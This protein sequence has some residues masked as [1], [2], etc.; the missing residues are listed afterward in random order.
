MRST[1]CWGPCTRRTGTRSQAR[2]WRWRLALGA[3][4]AAAQ[5]RRDVAV[6]GGIGLESS[7]KRRCA[8][9]RSP[10]AM[11]DLHS[12]CMPVPIE[13]KV[14]ASVAARATKTATRAAD[15]AQKAG[16]QGRAQHVTASKPKFTPTFSFSR[17]AL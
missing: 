17:V 1:I 14:A 16:P 2:R 7:D 15:S 8:V 4:V 5:W 6:A 9:P 3:V 10:I 12:N 13:A 11:N